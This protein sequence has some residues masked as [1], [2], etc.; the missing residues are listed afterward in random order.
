[1]WHLIEFEPPEHGH[2]VRPHICHPHVAMTRIRYVEK[3][4]GVRPREITE[5]KKIHL[6]L[7]GMI[8]TAD[9]LITVRLGARVVT[10]FVHQASGIASMLRLSKTE[11]FGNRDFRR[12]ASWPGVL[13]FIS[14]SDQ[15]RILKR[16]ARFE[17]LERESAHRE[18]MQQRVQRLPPG[19]LSLP[20]PGVKA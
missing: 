1:M 15:K 3:K 11:R 10:T 9:P 5:Q 16:L 2:S 6:D 8:H 18:K 20:R 17:N 14:S 19:T 12:F 7:G 13:I 4:Y